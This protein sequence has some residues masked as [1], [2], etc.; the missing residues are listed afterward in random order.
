MKQHITNKQWDEL[1]F[2]Q[3]FKFIG[4]CG[5]DVYLPISMEKI[6]IGQ[7]IEYLG[8]DLKVIMS[9]EDMNLVIV[10]N[11]I[12]TYEFKRVELVDALWEA[13][14]Y[15]LKYDKHNTRKRKKLIRE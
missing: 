13:T 11:S 12:Y 7:L 8:D 9:L 15:K 3:A 6:T 1:T 2:E 5:E 4:G 14:K 10:K